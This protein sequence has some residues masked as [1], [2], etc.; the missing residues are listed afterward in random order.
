[1]PEQNVRI[2]HTSDTFRVLFDMCHFPLYEC[3]SYRQWTSCIAFPS[4]FVVCFEAQT[5]WLTIF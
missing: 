4:K 2:D 5:N 3:L 1:M